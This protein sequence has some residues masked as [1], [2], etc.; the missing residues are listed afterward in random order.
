M[1]LQVAQEIHENQFTITVFIVIFLL[2]QSIFLLIY[3]N[4]GTYYILFIN[5]GIIL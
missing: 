2:I 4:N 1:G 3:Y 5:S